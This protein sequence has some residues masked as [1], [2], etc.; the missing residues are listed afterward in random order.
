[1]TR[2]TTKTA[3][4]LENALCHVEDAGDAHRVVLV[5]HDDLAVRDQPAVEQHVCRGPG[6]AIELDH[7]TRLEGEHVTHRHS[8]ASDLHGERH[9]HVRDAAELADHRVVADRCGTGD[10]TVLTYAD[11]EPAG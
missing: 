9:L 3:S 8:G 10:D 11:R 7:R 6:G 1:M 2:S 4:T 5:D